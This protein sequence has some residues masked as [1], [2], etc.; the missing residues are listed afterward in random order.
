MICAIS[1]RDPNKVLF[2]R[3][4]HDTLTKFVAAHGFEVE[5]HY[6]L[7][8]AWRARFSHGDGGRVIG[9]N[10][11]VCEVLWLHNESLVIDFTL[12]GC[13]SRRWSC[14]WS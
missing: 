3:Y 1:R 5:Q 4:A 12:D 11:E 2:C 9:V 8:T 13:A 7:P 10:S 6:L 14:L